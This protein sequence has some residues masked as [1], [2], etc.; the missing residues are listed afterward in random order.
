MTARRLDPI[1]TADLRRIIIFSDIAEGDLQR[2]AGVATLEH[3]PAGHTLA[4]EGM[5]S[6]DVFGI[7]AGEVEI[8]RLIGSQNALLA[9]R[10]P[11][12]IIG[13]M[14]ALL[15]QP[16]SATI[17][18]RSELTFL[19]IPSA[20]FL[21]VVLGARESAQAV[22]KI[23]AGRLQEATD[24]VLLSQKMAAL[25]TLAAGITHELNNPA[26]A[27]GRTI[28]Q[29]RDAT[30]ELER[31]ALAMN[32]AVGATER[33]AQLEELR[34]LVEQHAQTP[35]MLGSLEQADREAEVQDWLE[36][37]GVA[38]AWRF[39]TSLVDA[40]WT[41]DELEAAFVDAPADPSTLVWLA[42]AQATRSLLHQAG[43]ATHSITEI[44]GAVKSYTRLDHAPI[45]EVDI[46]EGLAQTLVM[47]RYKLRG[48]QVEESLAADLPRITAK[49]TEL[50]QV[51]TNLI[52]NAADALD[53]QGRLGISARRDGDWLLVEI[54][55]SGPGIPSPVLER[56]FEPFFTTKPQGKGTG[57]GLSTSFNI[58][59]R[60][61]GR[62]TATSEPGRTRFT[63]RLPTDTGIR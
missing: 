42:A 39:A 18:A 29:L 55:D 49:A 63:V 30:S 19:R 21:E 24:T 54:E 62:L 14:A 40:G 36:Q 47:L 13:E 60:H 4:A 28:D 11:G 52:D 8:F 10:G 22:V 12:Q 3:V 9:V 58:I 51:W 16:R 61:N 31:R 48:V 15:D 27:L 43:Q 33:A 1:T 32:L 46:R 34:A 41:Q 5:E 35:T 57:L 17:M 7:L 45:Q 38:A 25:G 50:I 2:L 44:V 53:G 56:I 26:A 6:A 37:Q 20:V 59:A 23:I